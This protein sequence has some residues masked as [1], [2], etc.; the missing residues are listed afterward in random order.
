MNAVTYYGSTG[1]YAARMAA[2]T[3]AKTAEKL[4]R[5]S[6][7]LYLL[8]VANDLKQ[9]PEKYTR[10]ISQRLF[11]LAK[12][13]SEKDWTLK[14][15]VHAKKALAVI[16]KGYAIALDVADPTIFSIRQPDLFRGQ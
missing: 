12:D 8:N 4:Q 15:V 6:M 11:R 7:I 13:I 1:E 9:S 2:L 10:R 14:D 16:D 3:A 5:E